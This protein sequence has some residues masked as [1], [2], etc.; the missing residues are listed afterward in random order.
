MP[1]R[2]KEQ[3]CQGS[4]DSL[5]FASVNLSAGRKDIHGK[6]ESGV[7]Y[8]QACKREMLKGLSFCLLKDSRKCVRESGLVHPCIIQ[9]LGIN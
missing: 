7:V 4:S 2:N 1:A 3:A 6:D 9:S 5:H 8:I